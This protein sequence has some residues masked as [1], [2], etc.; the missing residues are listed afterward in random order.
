MVVS[1]RSDPPRSACRNG[2]GAQHQERGRGDR[3][4]LRG[5]PEQGIRRQQVAGRDVGQSDRFATE[6]LV[7]VGHERH[8]AREAVVLDERPEG[9]DDPLRRGGIV[10]A[11]SQG[12]A[13]DD[14]D[15][16]ARATKVIVSVFPRG[17]QLRPAISSFNHLG[18]F[19][20][21]TPAP[22]AEA[23]ARAS[24]LLG[25][26]EA[27]TLCLHRVPQAPACPLAREPELGTKCGP[28]R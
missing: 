11:R 20:P 7:T 22:R 23:I 14:G 16:K 8:G 1:S 26:L 13:G 15:L 10:T 19:A 25:L 9:R 12:Q 21:R 6:D 3:L 4:R 5:D 24:A 28:I 17:S 27:D 2:P 18:L